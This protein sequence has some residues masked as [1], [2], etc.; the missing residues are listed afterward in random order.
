MEDKWI[1]EKQEVAFKH[2]F[3]QVTVQQVR[4]PDNRVIPDWPIVSLRNY[5]NVIALN[6]AGEFLIL[7]SYKH[8]IGRS[9]WQVLGGYIDPGEDAL[10]A[11]KREMLEET[12]MVSDSWLE[13]GTWIV[14]AN[15]RA[16]EAAF[17][18][19]RNCNQITEPNNDDLEDYTVHWHS[20]EEVEASIFN[21]EMCGLSYAS[22]LAFALLKLR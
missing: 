3:M 19:A 21:G 14:D 8:G 12:G 22:A 18:L 9:N 15:R 4:L 5:I 11:A 2:P 13:L 20:R 7:K 16:S 10:S 17:F 6:P 1:V